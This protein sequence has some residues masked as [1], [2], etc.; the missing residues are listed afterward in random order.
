[1]TAVALRLR[2]AL[3]AELDA[4]GALPAPIALLDRSTA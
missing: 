1:L 2:E 3:V 4:G